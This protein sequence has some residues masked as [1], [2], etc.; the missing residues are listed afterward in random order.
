VV[1]VLAQ[2]YS[3]TVAFWVLAATIALAGLILVRQYLR[4]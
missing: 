4:A 2:F 1:G 3:Y